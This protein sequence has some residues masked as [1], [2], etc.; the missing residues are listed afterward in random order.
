MLLVSKW[1]SSYEH[2]ASYKDCGCLQLRCNPSLAQTSTG[3]TARCRLFYRL[4]LCSL[5]NLKL[6]Y[7]L[8]SR[9]QDLSP[10][11]LIIF[12]ASARLSFRRTTL[13]KEERIATLHCQLVNESPLDVS[14]SSES[15]SRLQERKKEIWCIK[16]V[17]LGTIQEQ[18]Y[19]HGEPL[20][21]LSDSFTS[22]LNAACIPS[23]M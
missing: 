22:D 14:S 8:P 16:T 7:I 19:H 10:K 17:H 12:F 5:R 3:C 1:S 18:R 6:H 13:L 2:V 15:E 11:L 9:I 21:L 23:L 20:C 4:Q